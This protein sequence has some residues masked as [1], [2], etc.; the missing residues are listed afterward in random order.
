MKLAYLIHS[1]HTAGGM[2]KILTSKA[3]WLSARPQTEVYIIT[4]HLR[5][6]KPFF[7]LDPRIHLL[8][9]NVNDRIFG[10]KYRKQLQKVLSQIRPDITITLCG[11]DIYQLHKCT[12]TGAKIAEYHFLHDKF[13]RKYPT[14]PRYAAYRTKKLDTAL[15][16]YDAIAVLSQYDLDYYKA[17]F[18]QKENI[19]KIGNTIPTHNETLS[20]HSPKRFI[21]VGR[22]SAEKNFA[23]ALRIWR[24]VLEKHPD[25]DLDIYGE[26]KEKNRLQ[27]ISNSLGLGHHISLKGNS[28]TIMDEYRNSSGL[29]VTSRYEGFG[30]MVLEAASCGIPVVAYNCPG[31]LSELITEGKDGF[32]VK[33]GDIMTAS[34]RITK[35]IEDKDLRKEMGLNASEKAKQYKSERIMAQWV[36]LFENIKK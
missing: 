30:L 6:R 4:S 36:E 2:E 9:L 33:E 13:Y 28:T 17:K 27:E 21:C 14:H 3:N 12:D 8:D 35:L 32:L 23:D 5:G 31:G 19:I 7:Q 20:D 25:W 11:S 22:L 24:I 34:E 1:L 29:L 16:K 18:P 15:A 26:G 10:C